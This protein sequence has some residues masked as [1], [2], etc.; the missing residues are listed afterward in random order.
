VSIIL[1][2]TLPV[3][4]SIWKDKEV[5]FESAKL[6]SDLTALLIFD[7]DGVEALLLSEFDLLVRGGLI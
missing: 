3:L 2:T 1:I 7:K 5:L 6:L 4:L